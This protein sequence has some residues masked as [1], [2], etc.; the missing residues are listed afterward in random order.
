[1]STD[2]KTSCRPECFDFAL[3]VVGDP[4]AT[5]LRLYVEA[6]EA[7]CTAVA[8]PKPQGAT[9]DDIVELCAEHEFMLGVDGANEDESAEGLLE[10]ACAVLA[11]WGRPVIEPVPVTE[12]LPG[13]GDKNE[14]GEVWVEEPGYSHSL[15]D[16][17]DYDWEPHRYVLRDIQDRDHRRNHRWVPHW[18]L[19]VPQ[20][21]V[22]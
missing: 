10:I 14:E 2:W 18:A 5:E 11:R 3:D 20:Q 17:G 15:A 22:E 19:P 4:E 7:R 16:T 9:L 12:R 8:Q 6:L 1:M 21:E 13:E